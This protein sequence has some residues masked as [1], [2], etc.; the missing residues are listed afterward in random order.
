[1]RSRHAS[2]KLWINLPWTEIGVRMEHM[3]VDT[4]TLLYTYIDTSAIEQV[5][6]R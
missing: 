2:A 3:Q 5:D 4:R 1:M 6:A